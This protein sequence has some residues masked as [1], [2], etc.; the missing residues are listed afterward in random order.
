[1]PVLA[2]VRSLRWLAA[3][4]LVD[5]GTETDQEAVYLLPSRSGPQAQWQAFEAVEAAVRAGRHWYAAALLARAAPYL[6]D[7]DRMRAAIARMPDPWSSRLARLAGPPVPRW[8]RDEDELAASHP[9]IPALD[10]LAAHADPAELARMSLEVIRRIVTAHGLTQSWEATT[11]WLGEETTTRQIYGLDLERTQRTLGLAEQPAA[12]HLNVYVAAA[13]QDAPAP[14]APLEL[15]VDYILRCNIGRADGRS[16]VTGEAARFPGH[17]LPTGPLKLHI[18]LFLDGRVTAAEPVE[19]PRT[20]DSPWVELPLPRVAEPTVLHGDV[21]VYYGAAI[22]LM[23]ELILP[24][25]GDGAAGP[26]A[27]LRYRLSRSLADLSKAEGR[28]MSLAVRG[29]ES[30]PALLVNDL[31]FAPTE[32]HYDA[33]ETEKGKF[34]VTTAFYDAHFSVRQIG[35]ETGEVSNFSAL[36]GHPYAKSAGTLVDDLRKLALAGNQVFNYLF[37]PDHRKRLQRMIREEARARQRPPVLQAVNIGQQPAFVPWAALYD[38]PLGSDIA[39]YEP[40]PSIAEFGPD[41]SGGKPGFNCPYEDRH[42]GGESWKQNQ[43]C[44]WGFWGLS[45]I[46]EYPPSDPARDLETQVRPVA[47]PLAIL[48]GYDTRL[49]A[50]LRDYHLRVLREKH[51][52]QLLQPLIAESR[53]LENRLG[54]ETMDV[55]YLYCHVVDDPRQPDLR[56][57]AMQFGDRRVTKQDIDMWHDT[58]WPDPH[59]PRRHPLVVINGCGSAAK[60]PG[61]LT[62]LVDAFVKTAGASGVIGTEISIEQGLGGWAMELFLSALRDEPV[63]EALRTTRWEMFRGGNLIGLAY[64]PYC[65]AGLSV[66]PRRED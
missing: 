55:V 51:G 36:G 14:A 11:R 16:L 42:W 33:R 8:A 9:A 28:F 10:E 65:L 6:D 54:G 31:T 13:G 15:A 17:L 18:V 22:V 58:S 19:L 32:M 3:A 12:R 63:G 20:A 30:A 40:C 41:G 61:S 34:P 45:A 4:K 24:F 2:D 52:D 44:P 29:S 49:D 62:S 35:G 38:L 48:V 60:G 27:S 5:T 57:P 50:G 39:D 25:G 21:A 66:S 43:L 53:T 64:T 59:W 23:Y 26:Q 56:V 1:M 37:E 46:I 7:R 47:G